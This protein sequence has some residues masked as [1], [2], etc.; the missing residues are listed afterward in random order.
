MSSNNGPIG[1]FWMPSRKVGGDVVLV[2]HVMTF[3]ELKSYSVMA[4][5]CTMRTARII[6]RKGMAPP[7]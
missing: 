1:N 3:V 5:K 7:F 2:S 6:V 4:P